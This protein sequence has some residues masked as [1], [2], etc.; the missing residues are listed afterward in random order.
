[1]FLS[2]FTYLLFEVVRLCL[3]VA[4]SSFWEHDIAVFE[5]AWSFLSSGRTIH[6]AIKLITGDCVTLSYALSLA[7]GVKVCANT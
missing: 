4:N 6:L 3:N 2:R 1:V 5:Q 7:N